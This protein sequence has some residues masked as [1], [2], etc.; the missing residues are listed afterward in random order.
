VKERRA[1]VSADE[2]MSLRRQC[3][4]LGVNRSSLY[5]QPVAPDDEELALM[6]RIDELHLKYPFF[7]S[8]MM[9]ATLKA[10]GRIV[11]RKRTQR[12]MRLMGLESV[13]PKPNTSKPAPEHPRYPYLLRGLKICRVNQVWAADITYIPMARGFGYLVAV[14]DWY[15]RLVLAWRLSNTMDAGFCIEAVRAAVRRYAAPEIFNTDQGS[16]FTADDFTRPLLNRGVKISMDGKGRCLD[17]VFVERL[18]RSLKY[19]EVYLKAYE[20][21][22]EGRREIGAYMAFFNNERPHRSLGMQTPAAFYA[23]QLGKA[24]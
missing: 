8:R 10:E 3:E 18:W 13:A 12:L 22:C 19:E 6:R 1:L 2:S 4:L 17:N 21:L 15:S 9:S 5:Y 7:G 16:Q 14:I 24:A 11:N 20:S 23:D